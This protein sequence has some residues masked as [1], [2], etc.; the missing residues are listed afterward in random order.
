MQ[1]TEWG[2]NNTK[3][4]VLLSIIPLITFFTLLTEFLVSYSFYWDNF[5]LLL[6]IIYSFFWP[7][8]VLLIFSRQ[9]LYQ[10]EKELLKRF[11]RVL[12]ILSIISV[13][14][15][16]LFNT[17]MIYL[18]L[19]ITRS[20]LWSFGIGETNL[21]F[22]LLLVSIFVPIIEE[23]FKILPIVVLALLSGKYIYSIGSEKHYPFTTSGLIF[24]SIRVPFIFGIISGTMFNLLEIFLYVWINLGN[25]P[26]SDQILV[27]LQLLLRMIN[28]LHILSTGIATIGVVKFIQV[29]LIRQNQ[30]SNIK[31]FL[32]KFLPYFLIA[33]FIHGFWNGLATILGYL[34]GEEETY[35]ITGLF[36]ILGLFLNVI[37]LIVIIKVNSNFLKS[38]TC[39]TC[40]VIGVNHFHT[41]DSFEQKLKKKSILDRVSYYLTQNKKE[42]LVCEF[43]TNPI[44][45]FGT[46]TKCGASIYIA[47]PKCETLISPVDKECPNCNKNIIPIIH[48][49]FNPP[50]SRLETFFT[51]L[52]GIISISLIS[53]ILG[54]FSVHSDIAG[55]QAVESSL[56]MFYFLFGLCGISGVFLTL[57]RHKITTNEGIL[58][59]ITFSLVFMFSI[60]FL[61]QI[62]NLGLI[63]TGNIQAL[64]IGFFQLAVF[65]LVSY[66]IITIISDL[67]V[68]APIFESMGENSVV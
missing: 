36:I 7:L 13:V 3:F 62:V 45:H 22:N 25:L 1:K 41:K 6:P 35:S 10:I 46:C 27:L 67:K 18:I 49:P 8:L 65:T 56:L 53:G 50:L 21:V 40:P 61:L 54:V 12:V 57:N 63:F 55:E 20:D 52:T 15:T 29:L 47:C 5:K 64:L 60:V 44:E 19:A 68:H 33:V 42:K 32:V 39:K 38:K 31:S 9:G 2:G 28:P 58:I 43:C 48:F 30:Q 14:G 11:T 26:S 16:L 23:T 51:G 4:F 24:R 59:C 66:R 34:F 17:R 37:L